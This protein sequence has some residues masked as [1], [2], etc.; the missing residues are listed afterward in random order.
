M[1]VDVLSLSGKLWFSYALW[2]FCIFLISL[3]IFLISLLIFCDHFSI[4]FSGD[5]CT[6]FFSDPKIIFYR[7]QNNSLSSM[8]TISVYVLQLHLP[9]DFFVF[10]LVVSTITRTPWIFGA[11]FVFVVS[12]LDSMKSNLGDTFISWPIR[13][14]IYL[15]QLVIRR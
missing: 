10:V 7:I 8:S 13:N 14:A 3:L 5:Q 15:T 9:T 1:D 2:I 4:I 12:S 6:V 11:T